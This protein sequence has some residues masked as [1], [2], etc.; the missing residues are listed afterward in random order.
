[1]TIR[2]LS[3]AI[4]TAALSVACGQSLPESWLGKWDGPEGTSLQISA[5]QGSYAVTI[6]N[7][8]G[9][10]TFQAAAGKDQLSFERDGVQETIRPTDGAGTGMKWLA[11]KS[12]CLT[13][14][15]GE[16]FCRD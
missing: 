8:D 15:L 12:R 16:G 6:K 9:A 13:V 11:S 2:F 10:R 5:A 3:L 4:L 7:L 1:M 14:K